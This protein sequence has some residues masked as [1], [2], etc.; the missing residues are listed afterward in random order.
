MIQAIFIST[1]VVLLIRLFMMQVLDNSYEEL[2]QNNVIRERTIYPSRGLILDRNNKL[3]VNNEAVYDLMVIPRQAKLKDTTKLCQ[4][5][6]I[7]KLDFDKAV[8][9]MKASRGYSSYREQVLLKQ[10]PS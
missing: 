8:K 10:I 9:R 2:A 1:A 5:L 6:G 4:L 7:T 3:V